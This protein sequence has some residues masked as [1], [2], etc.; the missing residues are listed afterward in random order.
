M[1]SCDEGTSAVGIALAD[2]AAA[3]THPDASLASGEGAAA[4]PAGAAAVGAERCHSL[5]LTSAELTSLDVRFVSL[6]KYDG[7]SWLGVRDDAAER[8][9]SGGAR[10]TGSAAAGSMAAPRRHEH[11]LSTPSTGMRPPSLSVASAWASAY[12]DGGGVSER[13]EHAE[14]PPCEVPPSE[15]GEHRAD[16]MDTGAEPVEPAG[17][18]RGG[19]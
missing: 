17:E 6:A 5:K 1:A 14:V 2:G 13:D 8:T 3:A 7:S 9:G 12:S 18:G 11:H 4:P 10:S 19:T 16:G 15:A